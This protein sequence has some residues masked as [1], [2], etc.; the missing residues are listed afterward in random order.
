[1]YREWILDFDYDKDLKQILMTQATSYLGF[2]PCVG[3]VLVWTQK[4]DTHNP[5]KYVIL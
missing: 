1:M 3:F 5:L 2:S 4:L